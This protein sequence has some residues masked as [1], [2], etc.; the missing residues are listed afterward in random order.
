M[1]TGYKTDDG[2]LAWLPGDPAGGSLTTIAERLRADEGFSIGVVSTVP[3]SHATPAAFVSHNV[4]RNNY[5]QIACG[6]HPHGAAGGGDRRRPSRLGWQL[7]VGGRPGGTRKRHNGLHATSAGRQGPTAA[8]GCWPPPPRW[9]SRRAA[10]CSAC[11]AAAAATSST[12]SRPIR[13]AAPAS[14]QG[15]QENPTL[16]EAV[17][18]TL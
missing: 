13:R 10:S 1:S 15:S 4:S 12:T 7:P 18:A 9:T 3:F 16:A 8:T 11:S 2:N 6:D 14:P 5:T 17:Q